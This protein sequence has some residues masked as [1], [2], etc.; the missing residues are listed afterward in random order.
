MEGLG[1][2]L[3]SLIS[4]LTPLT[5]STSIL[6]LPIETLET[7][8]P[9]AGLF[10]PNENQ[11]PLTENQFP[12]T[13]IQFPLTENKFPLAEIQFPLT[14]NQFPQNENDIHSHVC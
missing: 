13:E 8:I 12:L 9:F 1:C 2:Q 14:E 7:S 6:C 11:F 10:L 5:N 3:W 4:S